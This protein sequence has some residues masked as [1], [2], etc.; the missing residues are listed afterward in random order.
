M[1]VQ[2]RWSSDRYLPLEITMTMRMSMPGD[3]YADISTGLL[4][5]PEFPEHRE[6]VLHRRL[7]DGVHEGIAYLGLP[8][9]A[10]HLAVDIMELQIVPAVDTIEA[11]ADIQHLASILG[12]LTREMVFNLSNALE[13]MNEHDEQPQPDNE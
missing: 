11:E 5:Q 2:S 6:D 13:T 10:E 12:G 7:Y 3:P 9:P 8:L 4:F 1:T